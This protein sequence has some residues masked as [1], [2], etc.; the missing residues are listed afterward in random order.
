[1]LLAKPHIIIMDEPTNHLDLHSKNVIKNML[2]HFNG[3]SMIV[4]H[5]RDLLEST[6][7]TIWLIKDGIMNP[8]ASIECY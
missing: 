6:S 5:D 8:N 3:T 4:S 7:N 2:Q 1:M